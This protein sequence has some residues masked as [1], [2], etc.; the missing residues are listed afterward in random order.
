[1]SDITDIIYRV[2]FTHLDQI[3][4]LYS[5]GVSEETLVGFIE[6]DGILS[7]QRERDMVGD[8][9]DIEMLYDKMDGV[10]RTYIP[11]HAIV[12][13]DELTHQYYKNTL[14][15]AQEPAMIRP[16]HGG[17]FAY[18]DANGDDQ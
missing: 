8:T 3:Y 14:K 1:M 15:N 2:I 11:M 13:I 16:I 5:K 7:I 17:K 10:K 6:V 18:T 4:T 12:R 9:K